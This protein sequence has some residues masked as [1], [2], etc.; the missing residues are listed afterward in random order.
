MSFSLLLLGLFFH[1]EKGE[2]IHTLETPIN[3][4]QTTR[5]LIPKHNSLHCHRC[6]NF[7]RNI[8]MLLLFRARDMTDETEKNMTKGEAR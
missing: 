8:F 2:A 3:F 4:Y 6:D 5:R 1:T 7:K